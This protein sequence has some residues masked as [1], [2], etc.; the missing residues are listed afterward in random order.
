MYYININTCVKIGVIEMLTKKSLTEQT[1]DKLR[2]WIKNNRSAKDVSFPSE[3][4]LCHQYKLSR[5]TIR[6][7]L[8]ILKDENLLMSVPGKGHFILGSNATLLIT[9]KKSEI[10]YVHNIGEKTER[11]DSLRADIYCGILASSLKLGLDSYLSQL[12]SERLKKVILKKNKEGLLGVIFDWNDPDLAKFFL[13]ENIPFVVIEGDFDELPVGAVV[14]DDVG[15]TLAAM[16]KFESFGHKKIAY[17]GYDD[18][19]VHKNRRLGAFREFYLRN[20]VTLNE[21]HIR[22]SQFDESN[23]GYKDA[24]K[25]LSQKDK[26]SAVFVA[27]RELLVG[28]IGACKKLKL[29]IPKDL[30]VIVWGNQEQDDGISFIEWDRQEMGFVAAKMLED[31]ARRNVNEKMQVLIPANLIN[32]KSIAR[33]RK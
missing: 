19:W 3:S 13:K 17:F 7:S 12:T 32:C 26:P 4:E 9:R 1:T 2:L 11:L 25:L 33:L 15:G 10:L 28:L 21:K 30:S 20:N 24:I 5:V 18:N 23:T 16:E 27:N 31:R 22:L 14:Q 29:N 8:Q 6:R